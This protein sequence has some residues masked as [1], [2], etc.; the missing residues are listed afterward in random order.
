MEKLELEKKL[1]EENTYIEYTDSNNIKFKETIKHLDSL[2]LILTNKDNYTYHYKL[3][4]QIVIN[5]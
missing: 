5:E 1:I 3:Y 2:N 4:E